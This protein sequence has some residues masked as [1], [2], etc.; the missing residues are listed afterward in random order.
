[1]R[2]SFNNKAALHPEFGK[3]VCIAVWSILEGQMYTKSIIW[4]EKDILKEFIEILE[5]N[6]NKTIIW[7]NILNFDIPF[8]KKRL[9]MH[10]MCIPGPINFQGK[11]PWEIKNIIDV[12]DLWKMGGN[13][14]T[15]LE[16]ICLSLWIQNPKNKLKGSDVK[17]YYKE[18]INKIAE[19]CEWDVTATIK[20]YFKLL[21]L[22]KCE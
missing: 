13:I 4:N 7:F 11:K 2:E 3:I 6:K 19:Y 17:K 21:S 18:N 9:M 14:S 20:V 15:S 5:R 22:L 12:M 10:D 8:I 1:M 16:L